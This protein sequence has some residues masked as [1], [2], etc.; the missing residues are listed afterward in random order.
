MECFEVFGRGYWYGTLKEAVTPGL[1][2]GKWVLLEIDVDGAV[3]VLAKFPAAIT[4]FIRP[5]SLDEL[6]RRLRLRGTEAEDAIKRRLSV[7]RRELQSAGRYT[8]QVVND[9]VA[10][11]VEEICGI[12]HDRGLSYD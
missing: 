11:A 7:A 2:A 8:Y 6:E 3:E 9:T 5:S 12:L 1:K 10:E 4:I